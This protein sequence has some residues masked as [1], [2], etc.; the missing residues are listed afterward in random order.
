MT[1]VYLAGINTDGIMTKVKQPQNG[2][3]LERVVNGYTKRAG[4]IWYTWTAI[5]EMITGNI[6]HR[7]A[8][9]HKGYVM[10]LEGERR[11]IDFVEIS[12]RVGK[13]V[14]TERFYC[15]SELLQKNP[16]TVVGK[17]LREIQSGTPPK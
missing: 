1:G 12:F 5:P 13:D 14:F 9:G 16:A 15:D 3:Q 2:I 7:P 8:I 11:K 17:I 10:T 6:H 4:V